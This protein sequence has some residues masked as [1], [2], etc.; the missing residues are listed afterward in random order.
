MSGKIMTLYIRGS[1]KKLRGSQTS[2]PEPQ[3]LEPDSDNADVGSIRALKG[4]FS[5]LS[6]YFIP[7]LGGL[8]AFLFL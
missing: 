8:T 3:G 7:N 5:V 6:D 4:N 2:T 1:C